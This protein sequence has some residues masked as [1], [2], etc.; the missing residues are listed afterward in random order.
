[1]LNFVLTGKEI[2]NSFV[3]FL[4]LQDVLKFGFSSR[5]YV[6]LHDQSKDD[7]KESDDESSGK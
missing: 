1:M 3:V 7:I 2:A 6:I 4:S 5:E